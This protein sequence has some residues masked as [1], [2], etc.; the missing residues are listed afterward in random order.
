MSF[1]KLATIMIA[2]A[3]LAFSASALTSC[4]KSAESII[5]DDIT[6]QFDSIKKI[7]G[8]LATTLAASLTAESFDVYGIDPAT[9]VQS[10]FKGF[11]YSIGEIKVDGDT[12]TAQVTLTCK[13]Y[14][15]LKAAIDAEAGKLNDDVE[16]IY[17]SH[18]E[19]YE[20]IGAI[21]MNALDSATPA[22]TKPIAIKYTK[23]DNEWKIADNTAQTIAKALI[24]N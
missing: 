22:E 4:G 13:S 18:D 17:L 23:K 24:G 20:R 5:K 7:D 16:F 14:A 19:Q 12:A 9:F 11:D 3:L 10:Y 1:K 8:D 2:C 15:E 21:V 6:R